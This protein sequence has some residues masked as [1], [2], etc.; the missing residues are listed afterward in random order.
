MCIS[1]AFVISKMMLLGYTD[2]SM[3]VIVSTAN[4]VEDDWHNRTQGLWI[5]PRCAP[6]P[7]GADTAIGD[8]ATAFREDLVRYLVAYN[9]AKLQPWIARIRRSDFRD[10]KYMLRSHI[11][12]LYIKRMPN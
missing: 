2:G 7:D 5:S 4:L 12:V 8:S 11:F 3:R 9:L 6:L 1:N 10:V